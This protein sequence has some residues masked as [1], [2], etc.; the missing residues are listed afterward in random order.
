MKIKLKEITVREL[1]ENHENNLGNNSTYKTI[2]RNLE[3]VGSWFSP[4]LYMK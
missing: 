1:V 4:C 2:S 3:N